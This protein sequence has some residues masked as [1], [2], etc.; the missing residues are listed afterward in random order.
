M[1]SWVSIAVLLPE[2]FAPVLLVRK[3]KRLRKQDP[4]LN[5]DLFAPH[6]R[7]DWSIKGVAHRTL[8]RPFQ[9]IAQEPILVL[10]TI[11]LSVVY[12]M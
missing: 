1:T 3:A 5:K 6:E 4:E 8:L 9:I 7:T 12:G 10:I 2:T 11:Y